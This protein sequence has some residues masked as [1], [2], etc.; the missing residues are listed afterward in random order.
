LN[1]FYQPH[2]HEGIHYLDPEESRHCIKVLRKRPGDTLQLT[3][4]QGFFYTATL[5]QADPQRCVFEIIEKHA[6]PARSFSIHVAI[7][8]TKN[9]DRV[10][11]FVEKSVE[12]GIDAITLVDCEHTERTHIK[13]E[14]LEKLA[15]SAMKQSVK[16]SLPRLTGLTPLPAFIAQAKATEKFIAYVDPT[17]PQHLFRTAIPNQDYLVLIGPEGDFSKAELEL[18]LQHGFCKVSLGPSRLRTETAG[19]AACHALH[20][21]NTA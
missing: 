4:G 16:A 14:R 11:W 10:E 8:P 2:L 20:L 3:D 13:H 1:L 5:V 18:C 7:S 17:N 15:V 12:I 21:L 6:A 19:L 9:A